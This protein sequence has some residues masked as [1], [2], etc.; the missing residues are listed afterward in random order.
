M[1]KILVSVVSLTAGGAVYIL[2]RPDALLMFQWFEKIGIGAAVSHLRTAAAPGRELVPEWIYF[3][4]PQSLWLFS[5]I[6]AFGA[7]WG[8]EIEGHSKS[9]AWSGILLASVVC[10]EVGQLLGC[11]P[12]TFDSM[13]LA[14]I[15]VA[16]LFAW[17]VIRL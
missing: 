12:G 7:I 13:D 14:L 1:L 3:S 8:S 4:F 6:V 17:P 5:G 9:S 15:P 11:V 10:L 2:W 16:L